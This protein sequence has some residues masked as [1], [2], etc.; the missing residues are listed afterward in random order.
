MVHLSQIQSDAEK[1]VPFELLRRMSLT[2]D[3]NPTDDY[4]SSVYGSRWALKALPTVEMPE[5]EMPKDIAYR[6][7]RYALFCRLNCF[8]V[9]VSWGLSWWG[10]GG[11]NGFVCAFFWR[12]R[13]DV[14]TICRLMGIQCLS[15]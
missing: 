5:Q 15:E 14:G 10:F 1:D 13:D 11:A 9:K 12:G 3:S 7:I 8:F 4:T 6:L 2:D